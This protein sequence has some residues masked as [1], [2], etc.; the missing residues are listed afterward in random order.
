MEK[1]TYKVIALGLGA[2]PLLEVIEDNYNV[3]EFHICICMY[4]RKWRC[5]Y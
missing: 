4:Y 1:E 2:K 5:M 3:L